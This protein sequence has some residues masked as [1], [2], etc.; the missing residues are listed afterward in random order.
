MIRALDVHVVDMQ[1]PSGRDSLLDVLMRR[2]RR[3]P[4]GSVQAAAL[5][6]IHASVATIVSTRSST[7]LAVVPCLQTSAVRLIVS[8]RYC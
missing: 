7:S 3:V 4:R 5:F 1:S 6:F 2:A 8:R